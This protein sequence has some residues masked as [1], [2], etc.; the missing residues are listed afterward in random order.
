MLWEQRCEA[1]ERLVALQ[2]A[3]AEAKSATLAARA[4]VERLAANAAAA[5]KSQT[6]LVAA[7]LRQAKEIERLQTTV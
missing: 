1:E 2:R 4:R 3:L 6:A 5:A 7:K